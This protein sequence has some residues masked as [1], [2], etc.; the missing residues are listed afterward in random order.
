VRSQ[1]RIET[2]EGVVF[3]F[4]LASP[5][6]RMLAWALDTAITVAAS[7]AVANALDKLGTVAK[8]WTAALSLLIYFAFSLLY[9]IVLEW[10]WRGQTV[11]KRLFGLRVVDAHGLRLHFY[12]IALRNLLRAVDML[13]LCYLVGGAAALLSDKAQRLGDMAAGTIVLR[14][15][16]AGQPDLEQIAPARYNSLAAFPHLAARLRSRT[17]PEAA[18]LAVRALLQRDRYQP[19]ARVELFADLAAYFRAVAP[20]P[21]EA[22]EGLADEQYVRSVVRVLYGVSAARH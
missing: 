17:H 8:D 18:V 6:A 10:R 5:V 22:V 7:Q 3:S 4:T 20:Y 15:T 13:P 11:G 12:Q 2:P 21:E 14:E 9:S 16:A 1:L 19:D